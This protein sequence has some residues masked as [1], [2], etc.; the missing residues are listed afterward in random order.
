MV[1]PEGVT[2]IGLYTFSGCTALKTV[3]I[4]STMVEIG[5]AAFSGCSSLTSVTVT[6]ATANNW[7]YGDNISSYADG[8]IIDLTNSSTNATYFRDTYGGSK[9]IKN[10]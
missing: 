4:P 8:T 1:I 6:G 2:R 5:S 10:V 7:A 9:F 3:V